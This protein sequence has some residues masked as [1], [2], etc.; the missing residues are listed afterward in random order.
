M[1]IKIDDKLFILG[2]EFKV[3]AIGPLIVVVERM[4]E[5]YPGS[6]LNYITVP[7]KHYLELKNAQIESDEKKT[8]DAIQETT[9]ERRT[10]GRMG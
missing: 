7:K 10:T 3:A 5:K 1:D 4:D 2:N 8:F 9:L 6:Y